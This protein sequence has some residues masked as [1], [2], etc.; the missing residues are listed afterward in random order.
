[1][2]LVLGFLVILVHLSRHT[3]L[4]NG[5]SMQPL[6][7]ATELQNMFARRAR[8]LSM[9]WGAMYMEGAK[10]LESLTNKFAPLNIGL[11]DGASVSPGLAL[12]LTCNAQL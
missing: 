6:V 8:E 5:S 9:C 10:V 1:M 3:L 2:L 7:P 11:P 4:L 12:L